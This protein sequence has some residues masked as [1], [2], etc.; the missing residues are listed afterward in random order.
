MCEC[1]GGDYYHGLAALTSRMRLVKRVGSVK[2]DSVPFAA[3][4]AAGE[5][6]VGCL[7]CVCSGCSS[8]EIALHCRLAARPPGAPCSGTQ[9]TFSPYAPPDHCP[10]LP[11]RL[12]ATTWCRL[13]PETASQLPLF[14]YSTNSEPVS[15]SL[16]WNIH[17]HPSPPP[18]HTRRKHHRSRSIAHPIVN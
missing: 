7:C 18:T 11:P 15:Y 16:F 12:F 3:I 8:T 5:H 2:A 4:S 17:T 13:S 1:L 6:R 14:L 10:I 9:A